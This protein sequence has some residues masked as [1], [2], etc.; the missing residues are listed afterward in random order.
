M[1]ACASFQPWRVVLAAVVLI[2]AVTVAP[3]QVVLPPGWPS[4]VE[5]GLADGPNGAAAL[6]RTAPFAFRYQYLSGG[7]NTGTGW[8][9]WNP[10]GDFARFYIEESIAAGVIPVFSYYMLLQSLPG[11]GS[12]SDA[13]YAN[14]NNTATMVA[15]YNDL[16]L[17]LRKA[18]AFPSTKV[19]LHVEPDFWGYMQQ[20]AP[21][22]NAR[23]VSVKVSETGIPQL[24]GL[25]STVAGFAQALVRLR[26]SYAPNVLLGYHVSVWGT[27]VDIALQDPPDATVDQLAARSVAFYRSLDTSF[28]MLFGEFSD[29]DSGFYQHVVG[30]NG[31]SW[32]TLDDFRR[33]VRYLG[34][35]FA[36]LRKGIVLWQIPMG[37]TR[38]RSVNNVWGH[39]Q[40]NRTERLLDEPSRALLTSYRDAG[41]VAFLFGGGAA[42][43]TCACDA[44]NDGVT[45]PAATNGNAIVSELATANT[46]P[47]L[48]V[49]GTTPTLVTP[50]AANDDGG[51]LRWRAW[52]YYQDGRLPL[53]GGSAQAP[54][55][56]KNVR[57]GTP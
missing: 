34:G 51:F 19:V 45:N 33:H 37:N 18:G 12:E 44:Q 52:K 25:P 10:G 14:A 36:A 46:P 17:F 9:T 7:A 22:D 1:A 6:R 21:S 3:A 32:W 15:Y 53:A 16:I 47:S 29:R 24:A 56:P 38:M 43:T 28:D 57:V 5:L 13:D 4:N 42:G 49:R 23:A 20:R 41:V 8:S 48:V 30:D 35:I 11:G 26:D 27:N 54:S 31:R 2:S 50:H 39:Y 55:A 40:D